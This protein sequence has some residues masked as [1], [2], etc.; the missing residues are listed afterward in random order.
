MS[1]DFASEI[2]GSDWKSFEY[3]GA[4]QIQVRNFNTFLSKRRAH[5]TARILFSALL[6]KIMEL[7]NK[8]LLNTNVN[9]D[10][11]Y[12]ISGEDKTYKIK[13]GMYDTKPAGAS[14][15]LINA[16]GFGELS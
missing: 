9:N 8:T 6:E 12:S 7:G 13:I 14:F 4:P 15:K 11:E 2:G 5:Y 16:Y 3:A 1:I 10:I